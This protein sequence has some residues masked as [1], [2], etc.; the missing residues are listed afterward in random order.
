M[1]AI[2]FFELGWREFS[3]Q[4]LY[5][6]PELAETCLQDKFEAFPWRDDADLLKL[7]LGETGYP[8]VD[9]GMRSAPPGYMHNR[10]RRLPASF[11]IK[12]LLIDWR[13]GEKWFWECLVDADPANNSASSNGSP[14][15]ALMP[16]L[17]AFSTR[18]CRARN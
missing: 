8:I 7:E 17:I 13:E 9:A 6:N 11:L 12:H 10:V 14:V 1:M 2:S 3:Y 5:H 15:A 4:L 16:R 18:Y